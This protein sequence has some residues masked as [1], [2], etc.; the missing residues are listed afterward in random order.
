MKLSD[1]EWYGEPKVE[2]PSGHE[3]VYIL[4]G[5][6]GL[7]A[8]PPILVFYAFIPLFIEWRDYFRERRVRK[9]NTP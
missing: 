7:L 9:R 2:N 5:F 1:E 6:V 4:L 3:F 8:F